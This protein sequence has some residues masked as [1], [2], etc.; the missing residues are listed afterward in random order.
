[1]SQVVMVI[2]PSGFRDEE[3][4][5]P[6]KALEGRG[7]TVTTASVTPQTCIG[8]LGMVADATIAI[9]DVEAT[10]YDAVIFVGGAGASVFFDDADAHRLARESLA[11]GRVVAAICIAPSTLAHAGLLAGRRATAFSSQKDDLIAHGARWTGTTV[12]VDGPVITANGPAAAHGFGMTV[13]DALGL[14]YTRD[15][16]E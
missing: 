16:G 14:P 12:E 6:K 9:A 5:H 13:A 3:Y 15:E 7:A 10:D 4:D 8:K 2:A 11:L 1:M